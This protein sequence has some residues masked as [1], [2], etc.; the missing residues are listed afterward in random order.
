[1]FQTG[2]ERTVALH[3]K[4]RV[5]SWVVGG[6]GPVI[7]QLTALGWTTLQ[8]STQG[9]VSSPEALLA[10]KYVQDSHRVGFI[11]QSEPVALGQ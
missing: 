10:R 9:S 3:I 1:M 8:V 11:G 2:S 5:G 6:F 4:S 7:I